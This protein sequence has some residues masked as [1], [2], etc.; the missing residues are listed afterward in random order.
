METPY[1][2]ASAPPSY[3]DTMNNHPYGAAMSSA[4]HDPRSSSMQSLVPEEDTNERRRKLLL[5]YLHG[6][7]GNETS[8]QSFPAHVHNLVTILVAESH[9]VHT[10]IYPRYKSRQ[11]I[12]QVAEDF[13]KWLE[14]HES[15]DTDV[16]LLGH[17]MGGLLS[18]EVMLL[19]PPPPPSSQAFR[20]RILGTINFDVPFLGIHPGVVSSGLASIFKPAP[21]PAESPTASPN[22][23][24]STSSLTPTSPSSVDNLFA[25]PTDP[26]FNPKFANDTNIA[27]RKGWQS[28]LHFLTKHSDGLR[29]AT[30]Q[31]VKS[32]LEFGGAMADYKSLLARYEKMR[33]LE[34]ED[35]GTRRKAIGRDSSL[36]VP[37]V[38]FINY[39]TACSGRPKK[40]KE[41]KEE[42][43]DGGRSLSPS[44]RSS[45]DGGR[46]R[47]RSPRISI[48][49]FRDDGSVVS[50]PWE[51]ADEPLAQVAPQAVSDYESEEDKEEVGD[52]HSE[53]D[54]EEA[55]D[56]ELKAM[57]STTTLGTMDSE[58]VEKTLAGHHVPMPMWPP[59]PMEPSEPGPLEYGIYSDKLVQE[60]MKKDHDRRVKAYKQAMKDREAMIGD[61]KRAEDKIRKA[62]A[63]EI[64]KKQKAEEKSDTQKA[65]E[66]AKKQK[67]EEEAKKKK[68]EEEAKKKAAEEE[69]KKKK[70]EEKAA[71]QAKKAEEKAQRKA[72]KARA[73]ARQDA[74]TH[75]LSTV[76]TASSAASGSLALNTTH[77][78]AS[79]SSLP[80]SPAGENKKPAKDRKFCMLPSKGED[81]ER[82]PTWVRVYME[83]V[84]EVGAHCGLFA[85]S[86]TYERLVGEV[87]AK[88][89]EWV[90]D[91][92][93]PSARKN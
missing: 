39:Y 6:F 60:A 76:P 69:A 9:V 46:S 65:E 81:G 1:G 56:G 62:A 91:G 75:A 58:T 59:M 18:G 54:A 70:A 66:K 34:Y 41:E 52:A 57:E 7:M 45:V 77:P 40:L 86:P 32:H 33:G 88:V 24:T 90:G 10:K 30:K 17:S 36:T 28:T 87:G 73:D 79:T 48:E 80:T 35:A 89:E 49:E 5:I 4:G 8:F 71:K 11:N 21:A 14:P 85:V 53:H 72:Q 82:D 84:D 50:V 26:N 27:V 15:R 2:E 12:T 20:H 47:S 64:M 38:R 13:S 42:G 68:A 83:G 93:Y 25:S 3:E 78:T 55:D 23:T 44:G 22:A 51:E 37:R 74:D 19:A 67:A 92:R 63:K 31:Y 43:R 16:I 29:Q 61:R